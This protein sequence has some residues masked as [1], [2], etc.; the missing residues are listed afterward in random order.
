MLRRAVPLAVLGLA[1]LAAADRRLP[2]LSVTVGVFLPSSREVRDGL[3]SQWLNFGVSPSPRRLKDRWTLLGDIDFLSGS[4][5]GSRVFLAPVTVGVAREFRTGARGP[6]PMAALR[7]G[8]AYMD[9]AVNTAEGRVSGKR[10]EPTANAEL[11]L[12]LSDSA[13]LSLRYDLFPT[14]EGLRFD[15]LSLS[16]QVRAFSFGRRD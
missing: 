12:Y 9:Y 15:G 5:R 6:V 10:L 2:D 14:V 8:I 1:S 3:G 13:L 11:G 7:A 16:L 4:E